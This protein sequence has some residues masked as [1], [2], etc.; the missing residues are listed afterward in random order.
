MNLTNLHAATDASKEIVSDFNNGIQYEYREFTNS[1]LTIAAFSPMIAGF[2]DM[3]FLN[4]LG[5]ESLTWFTI[6][7]ILGA[8]FCFIDCYKLLK[9]SYNVDECFFW[10]LFCL[11]LYFYLRK[12]IT[13]SGRF[14]LTLYLLLFLM[15]LVFTPA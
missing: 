15:V 13:N 7:V 1:F 2:I 8:V 9:L 10:A 5:I 3:Y 14:M 11:P 12:K 6:M 4:R